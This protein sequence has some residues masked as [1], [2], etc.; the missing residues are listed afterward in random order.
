MC[1][2]QLILR[3]RIQEIIVVKLRVL[4]SVDLNTIWGSSNQMWEN[5]KKMWKRRVPMKSAECSSHAL[6]QCSTT[7]REEIICV[8]YMKPFTWFEEER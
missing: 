5:F 4:P 2:T 1:E 6:H 7:M 8:Q 3:I